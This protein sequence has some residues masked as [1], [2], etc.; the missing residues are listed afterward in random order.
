MFACADD[1]SCRYV[2]PQLTMDYNSTLA[3]E[4]KMY[5]KQ[6]EPAALAGQEILLIQEED[7]AMVET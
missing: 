7:S 5:L 1:P 2:Y 3:S 6:Q 4:W